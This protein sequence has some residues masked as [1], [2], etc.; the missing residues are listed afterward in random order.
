MG[1]GQ[2][3]PAYS[4]P[5][6]DKAIPQGID[7]D[8]VL[9]SHIQ[10]FRKG[11]PCY[12]QILSRIKIRVELPLIQDQVEGHG[13]KHTYNEYTYIHL[14]SEKINPSLPMGQGTEYGGREI[15]WISL[16]TTFFIDLNLELRKYST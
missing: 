15:S 14:Q 13:G 11:C 2:A 7:L 8:P 16:T 10:S 5:S 9:I 6:A 1:E 3:G 12:L 4:T